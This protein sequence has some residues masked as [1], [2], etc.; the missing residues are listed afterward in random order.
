MLGPQAKVVVAELLGD[1]VDWNREHI[2][3]LNGHPLADR[4]VDLKRTDVVDLIARSK[5]QF[6]AILLDID[7]GPQAFTDAANQRLYRRDGML[8]CRH[9]LRK[10]GCLGVWS[11]EPN[12]RFEQLLMGCGFHVRRYSSPAYKGGKALCRFIWIASEDPSVLPPGGGE[13]RP[14]SPPSESWPASGRRQ[15]RR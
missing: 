15:R 11:A 12:K 13:P 7:N 5:G 6:D 8:A 3:V 2:G 9:A 4:R 10:H 14:P 1:V